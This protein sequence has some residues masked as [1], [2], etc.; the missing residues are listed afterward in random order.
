VAGGEGAG[1]CGGSL[2]QRQAGGEGGA[3]E[4]HPPGVAHAMKFVITGGS[5]KPNPLKIMIP[6]Y[7]TA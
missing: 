1:L 6:C 4:A 2:Q 7:S 5:V 3:F